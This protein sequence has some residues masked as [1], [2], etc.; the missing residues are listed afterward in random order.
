MIRNLKDQAFVPGKNYIEAAGLSTDQKPTA[1]IITGSR[2]LEV[3]TG[4]IYEFDEVSGT[5][6]KVEDFDGD[7]TAA[8]AAWLDAHPEATTTVEDGAISYA[9]LNSELKATADEVPELKSAIGTLPS[10]KTVQG[11]I[12]ALEENKADQNGYYESMTVGDAE[13][14]IATIGV[15]DKVPYNFRTAGGSADIGDREV[16]KLIG[17]TVAWNQHVKNGNFSSSSDWTFSWSS[18]SISDGYAT[19]TPNAKYGNL[20]QKLTGKPFATGHKYLIAVRCKAD[21]ERS[22]RLGISDNNILTTVKPIDVGTSWGDT[23]EIFAITTNISSVNNHIVFIRDDHDGD[24]VTFYVSSFVLF[25]LTQMFGSTIADYIYTLETGTA[26]AGVA[27]F[28]NLFPKPYY[29]YDAGSLQSVQAKSHIMT[30]FNAYNPTTEKAKVVDGNVYQ[31]TGTYTSISLNGET[32]TPDASGYFTPAEN[33]EI[34]V[35]GGN[36]TDTCIHLKW[37]GERDGEYEP[38]V[39][40]TYPLDADLTLR[41]MPK[42]D[43]NNKLYYDGDE[44]ASNGTVTRKYG[45]VDLGTLDWSYSSSYKL[46]YGELPNG[47]HAQNTGLHGVCSQYRCVEGFNPSGGINDLTQDYVFSVGSSF[48]NQERNLLIRDTHYTDATTF[49][50]A[51]SGVYLVYELATPTTESADA[52]QNPQIVDDWGTEE[53]VDAGVTASTPTRDVAIPVGHDTM[54]RQNLRAKL[55]MAPNS[56]DGDGDYIMRQT[57]GKNAYV[58]M[59]KELPTLPTENG[60]YVLKCTVDSG[61]ASLAWVAEGGE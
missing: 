30:R 57:S 7:I 50:T 40:H 59:E 47:V 41:G 35:T 4:D 24:F 11:Q 32:I 39:E 16:D 20:Q 15:E 14:L 31:I 9:K 28:R 43:S 13:Q 38:Y 8:V 60:T 49:K 29:A 44:Y 56:P 48:I 23:C 52:Y 33:G 22:L 17:G 6:S 2:F 25:D 21:S 27:W 26:G 3:D 42:L 51:M 18:G 1:G 61:T 10:G 54:Y 34:T 53:Y 45:I 19:I 58:L 12:D 46:F 37:D 36:S 55:E 5:W